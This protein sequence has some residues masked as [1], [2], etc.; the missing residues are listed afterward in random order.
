MSRR[1]CAGLFVAEGTSDLPLADLVEALFLDR[2]VR[3]S[4]SRPDFSLLPEKVNKDVGSRLL[5]GRQLLRQ[6]VDVVVVHRDADAAG[7]RA[8]M[9]ERSAMP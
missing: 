6:R 2:G 8:R 7:I 1:T 3:L 5:A 4:L 9:T